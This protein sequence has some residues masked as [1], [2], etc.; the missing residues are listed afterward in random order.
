MA[1]TDE[2]IAAFTAQYPLRDDISPIFLVGPS[3][4]GKDWVVQQLGELCQL[5]VSTT[6]RAIRDGEIPGQAYNFVDERVF[7]ELLRNG[8]MATGF[9]SEKLGGYYGYRGEDFDAVIKAGRIPIANVYYTALPALLKVFPNAR[10][11]VMMPSEVR[12]EIGELQTIEALNLIQRRL[13][14]RGDDPTTFENRLAD[15]QVQMLETY[16]YG[17]VIKAYIDSG[18]RLC[19]I[20]NDDDGGELV[21][22]ISAEISAEINAEIDIQ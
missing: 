12:N 9:H 8:D 3:G 21:A 10:I 22:Q 2:E 11:I 18:A 14:H 17:G 20:D 1:L 15:L 7:E 5:I 16:L 6:S 19:I 13:E 4:I